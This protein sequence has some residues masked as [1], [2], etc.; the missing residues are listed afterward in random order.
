[1]NLAPLRFLADENCDFAVVRALREAG[2]DVRAV[3]EGTRRSIDS[4]VI[5]TSA[6]EKRI[7]LTEDKDFGWLA[8]VKGVD[9]GVILIPVPQ[10]HSSLPGPDGPASRRGAWPPPR[11]LLHGGPAWPGPD[12]FQTW[13]R[14]PVE[15]PHS[16]RHIDALLIPAQARSA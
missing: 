7:L 12:D 11:Q 8:F 14:N 16:L 10:Q 1:M 6:R 4:E 9:A 13:R 15:P 5:E 3:A 2:Y